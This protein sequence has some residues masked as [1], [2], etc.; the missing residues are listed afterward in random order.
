M[1]DWPQDAWLLVAPAAMCAYYF[2]VWLAVGREP[3]RGAAVVRYEPPAGMTP[4]A[5]RYLWMKGSDGRSLAAVLADLAARGKVRVVPLD[6]AYRVENLA[7]LADKD[8]SLPPEE[9]RVKKLM[10]DDEKP[11][12]LR[13]D[14]QGPLGLYVHAIQQEVEKRVGEKYYTRNLRH[15]L[16]AA[17]A[18]FFFALAAAIATAKRDTFTTLFFCV[19][20][21]F[22]GWIVGS[23]MM[24]NVL[25]A[26]KRAF[27]GMGGLRNILQGTLVLGAFG[28]ALTFIGFRVAKGASPML[29][30]DLALFVLL[31]LVWAPALRRLTPLGQ[32]TL[33]ELEG[34]RAF[35]VQVEQDRLQRL[36][37][38]G[39]APELADQYLAYAIA[40]EVKEAWG[41]H[42]A[43]AFEA[44]TVH[45]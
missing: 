21:L 38:P 19:W 3:E 10:F 35:L 29:S 33:E 36:N 22:A 7:G 45:K 23:V 43:V 17:A 25:P 5:A 24:V 28:G 39:E 32:K 34:F 31:P 16:G 8:A 6:G 2:A 14:Q 37:R 20:F 18:A 4:A 9:A 26:W 30:A 27:T 40:L 42:L 15:V 44:A 13:P 41:D 11:V 12:V 1:S